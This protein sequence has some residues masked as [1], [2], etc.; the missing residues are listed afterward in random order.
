MPDRHIVRFWKGTREKYNF[1]KNVGILDPWMRYTVIEADESI[2]E[3]F[4]NNVISYSTGQLLPVKDIVSEMPENLQPGD[5]YLVGQDGDENTPA[6]YSI[7][8]V[9]P[10]LDDE[11]KYVLQT[12]VEDFDYKYGVR[13]L[14]HGLKNYVLVE[15]KLK[16]YDDVDCGTF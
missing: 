2:T 11:G 15:E 1:L 12:Q 9:S 13:V 7:V 8:S 6:H 10:T 5:R 4:G 3:Y 16:T 14:N